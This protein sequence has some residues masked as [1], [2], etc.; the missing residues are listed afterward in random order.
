MIFRKLLTLA[1]VLAIVPPPPADG[2]FTPREI[3]ERAAVERFLMDAEI[4]RTEP[5]G[6]GVTK[7]VRVFLAQGAVEGSAIWK[8]VTGSP[9][10]FPDE[11]RYEVAAYRV[12][13][14]L[15]LNMVP[16]TVPRPLEGKPGSLQL[17]VVT[18]RSLLDIMDQKIPIPAGAL[19][20]TERAKYL[21][22]AFDSL[23]ANDDRTQQN[24]RYTEDWRTILIDH[25]RSFRSTGPYAGTLMFGLH[26]IRRTAEGRPFLFRRLPRAFV[27]SLRA[28]TIQRLREGVGDALTEPEILAVMTRR[29]LLLKEI[30][31]MIREQGR[32][33]ILYEN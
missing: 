7:P 15:G 4:R 33:R 13:K 31:D 2:Q 29:D 23:I 10:G 20:A 8:N 3:S 16:P 19:E 5:V 22:R 21:T 1:A 28:L 25:S 17:W 14:L 27:D 32:D 26:G 18:R 9:R 11:W 24:V 12:D 6:E 30:D